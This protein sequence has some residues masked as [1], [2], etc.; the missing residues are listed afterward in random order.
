MSIY[1]ITVTFLCVRPN[2]LKPHENQIEDDDD[3]NSIAQCGYYMMM[4]V[5]V[6]VVT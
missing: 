3:T 5:A 2:Q 4:V 6:A 1:R